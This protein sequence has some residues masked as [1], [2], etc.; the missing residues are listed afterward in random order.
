MRRVPLLV[1]T[2][3]HADHVEGVPGVLHGR[4]VGVVAVSPLAEPS[5]EADRVRR[6]LSDAGVPERVAA[7]GDRWDGRSGVELRVVWPTRLL[8]GQGSD[9]NNASVTLVA[10][11]GGR[12]LL[13]GGDLE[14]AA[15]EAVLASGAVG[16][17][18]VVKVPH[19][20]SAQQAP[21]WLA[22]V[23]SRGGA[24]RGR[25]RQRLR[26]SGAGHGRRLPG[27]RVRRGAHRP[28]RRRRGA[29]A[30]RTD[31]WAWSGAVADPV[32]V[33][34]EGEVEAGPARRGVRRGRG[35][36]ACSL[37]DSACRAVAGSKPA[38][39]TTPEA[40]VVSARAVV[41]V[42]AED[43]L[44]E[45]V[46]AAIV[47]DARAARPHG[48][49]ARR[50]PGRRHRPWAT[51]V[52]ACSPNL[53][54]DAAVVVARNAES[55]DEAAVAALLDAAAEGE[56]RLVVLHPGGVKGR[57][58]V[59]ALSKGGYTVAP[60]REGQGTRGRRLHRA[61]A[62][63]RRVARR[64]PRRSSRCASRSATTC[65]RWRP[66]APSWSSD[67]QDDPLTAESV[68]MY[69]DG[70]ADVPGYLVSDAVLGG[71]AVEVLRRSRWAL[72]NDPGAGP[73]LSAA[74]ASGLR[75]LA[76]VASMPRGAPEAEVA[77][78]AGV[79]PFKVRSL[80][81]QAGRWHPASLAAALVSMAEADAAVKGRPVDGRSM[82]E[83]GLDREQ[84]T[85]LLERA[86]LHAVRHRSRP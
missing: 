24:D 7:P 17:V 65:G 16:D 75:G 34:V 50:R 78:E 44:A 6:W 10:T 76:R 66:R 1:L 52:E 53:F 33:G 58:V 30:R 19:H 2:H 71:R 41:A 62:A 42:G 18:D 51:L 3:F 83:D 46:V 54:G 61:R 60:V 9:P 81:E 37:D 14:P 82:S 27:R 64:L 49:A 57:K 55:A 36:V 72:A 68:A 22:D 5:G 11:V 67:V 23:A 45:R 80:R 56:V 69:Y 77:R 13:L 15:Q 32:A 79:P 28:R 12:A 8:R 59:D 25:R 40:D 86:L 47:A 70:V 35:R 21:G 43:F 31:V 73:A 48:R 29:S 63:Q 74:V 85:Y 39:S 4:S 38:A 84:G 26:P 20:G